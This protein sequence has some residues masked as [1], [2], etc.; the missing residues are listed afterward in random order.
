MSTIPVAT[1]P[2]TEVSTSASLN[3]TPEYKEPP[4]VR[5]KTLILLRGGHRTTISGK[6]PS[7]LHLELED[8]R[9]NLPK[10]NFY[11][12]HHADSPDTETNG[13]AVE[14]RAVVGLVGIYG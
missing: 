1:V 2:A 13:V 3:L 12:L 7:D 8:A 9:R 6:S 14:P 10:G 11:F 4:P 5:V